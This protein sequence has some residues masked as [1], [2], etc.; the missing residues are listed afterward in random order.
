MK[1]LL[2]A[3]RSLRREFRHGELATLAAALVLAVTALTAVGTL[4]SRVE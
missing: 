4:A 1:P 3:A 2:F